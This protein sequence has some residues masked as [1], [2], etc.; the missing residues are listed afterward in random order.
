MTI[1]I[2]IPDDYQFATQKLDFLHSDNNFHCAAMGD[3]SRDPMADEQLSSAEALILI[4]ERTVID[5]A[6]LRRT[7]NLKLISQTG[8][9]A[10][11]VD[12]DACTRAGVALVEGSGSPVAPAELTWLLIMASRRKFVSSV[13]AMAEGHW[14]TE[15]G[16]A[17]HN[18]VIGILGYGKIGKRLASYA[19]VFGMQVQVW[20]SLRA[21]EEAR[22][23][24]W[25][26]PESREQFFATS[27]VITVHQR[28]VA[29]TQGNITAND[30]ALMKTD[31]LFVNTSRAE[32]VYDGAL[33]N[34]LKQGRP[35]FAALDVY[36]D[37]PIYNSR[38]PYLQMP[39]VLCTPHLGYVE[40]DS[41]ALYFR[42]AFDNVVRYF[43]G[44]RSHVI[45]F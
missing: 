8:K 24:G 35:G 19:A 45:N 16:S 1:H 40:K 23:D 33:Q 18:Q 31:A 34:A 3:L 36:E 27:D 14:Q 42:T 13:K 38:H 6:F 29:A 30:L 5:E 7:P 41:Y 9:L 4:R 17:V 37:E 25:T 2:V 44:D 32:L 43:S 10:R 21:Q 22:A 28:L 11:N 12:I 20:G 15:I 26:V 39:N